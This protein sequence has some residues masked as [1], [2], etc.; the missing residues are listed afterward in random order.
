MAFPG[1]LARRL[2]V[3]YYA[4]CASGLGITHSSGYN[5]VGRSSEYYNRDYFY[6]GKFIPSI[7]TSPDVVIVNLG[8]N[9]WLYIK[10]NFYSEKMIETFI[11]TY[12]IFLL[13]IRYLNSVKNGILPPIIVLGIGPRTAAATENKLEMEEISNKM[14][15]WIE[16]A[17]NLTGGEKSEIY[18]KEIS[19]NPLIDFDNDDDFGSGDHWS[20][21]GSEKF[22]N[23]AYTTIYNFT[24]SLDNIPVVLKSEKKIL[25]P[26][27]FGLIIFLLIWIN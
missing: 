26:N 1:I 13:Q 2:N 23:G 4:I 16:K 18:Y 25:M 9:D 20:V 22:A 15:P 10:S 21:R 24:T 6:N 19:A 17:V 7:T 14:N 27:I 8:T 12:K 3:E 5:G 11:E